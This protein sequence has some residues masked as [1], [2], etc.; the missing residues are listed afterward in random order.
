M[1][2]V[3]LLLALQDD[4]SALVE[5]LRNEDASERR[6]VQA[7]LQRRGAAAL[8][9]LLGAIDAVPP[10][11]SAE[12]ERLAARLGSKSWKERNEATLALARLGR[13]AARLIEARIDEGA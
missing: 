12:V 7:E 2:S 6:R 13:P 9:A 11:P 8:P 5:R 3:L 4:P 1:I 10:A